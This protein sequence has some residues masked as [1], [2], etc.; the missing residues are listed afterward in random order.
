MDGNAEEIDLYGAATE[1][2]EANQTLT[3]TSTEILGV[4]RG[5]SRVEIKKAY[6]KVRLSIRKL[7][8]VSSNSL[9]GPS[10]HFQAI[11]TRFL[12]PSDKRPRSNSKP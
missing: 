4:S 12:R 5:A 7:E 11:Q 10:L 3:H 1:S 9:D 2:S 8:P 6:H